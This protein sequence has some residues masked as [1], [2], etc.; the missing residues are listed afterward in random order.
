[1]ISE[2]LITPTL[3]PKIA[4]D[5]DKMSH[6][7]ERQN[8]CNTLR[9]KGSEFTCGIRPLQIK[10]NNEFSHNLDPI[11][12]AR[13]L[14]TTI[15]RE[16]KQNNLASRVSNSKWLNPRKSESYLDSTNESIFNL[17]LLRRTT[18]TDAEIVVHET[19]TKETI[20]MKSLVQTNYSKIKKFFKC[21]Y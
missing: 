13:T 7:K 3:Y 2:N 12:W 10:K 21:C 15:V 1:M 19:T 9:K 14:N 4:K 16:H 6:A 17:K 8:K 5:N 11:L 18:N 20:L